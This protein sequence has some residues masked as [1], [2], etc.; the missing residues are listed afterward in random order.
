[1]KKC[2][3][4]FL[5]VLILACCST[6]LTSCANFSKSDIEKS[7]EHLEKVLLAIQ[8]EDTDFLKS[9]FSKKALSEV[10]DFDSGVQRL[11]GFF[12]GDVI[13]YE[14]QATGI[15]DQKSNGIRITKKRW[16]YTVSTGTGEY[17]FFF[18]EYP[19]DEA[20]PDNVGLYMLQVIK[21]EDR[22]IFFDGGQKIL[23]PGVYIPDEYFEL[24]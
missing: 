11:F 3:S 12:D 1:M 23:F 2:I 18:L 20:D 4:L 15:D 22:S 19:R 6:V 10:E 24:T 14:Y 8:N 9:L 17:L 5:A 7:N 16:W 13:S 21:A